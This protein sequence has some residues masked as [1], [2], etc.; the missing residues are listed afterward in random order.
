MVSRA[1]LGF[2]GGGGGPRVDIYDVDPASLLDRTYR[3]AQSS[4]PPSALDDVERVI[5]VNISAWGE[6]ELHYLAHHPAHVSLMAAALVGLA[7]MVVRG[8]II[9]RGSQKIKR[10]QAELLAQGVDLTNVD[11][12]ADT[13]MYLKTMQT[14]DMLPL[15]LEVCAMKQAEAEVLFQGARGVKKW[16]NYYAQRGITLNTGEDFDIVRNYVANLHHLEGCLLGLE[17]EALSN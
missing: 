11:K 10:I 8:N 14:A 7:L 5:R 13:L 12:R 4:A 3:H 2:G 16:R 17:N 6:Q 15:G 9:V 1:G